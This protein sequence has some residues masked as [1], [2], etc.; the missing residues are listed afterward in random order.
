M[1]KVFY[2]KL[3]AGNQI[4]IAKK[5]I[6]NDLLWLGYN[7]A[8]DE[9]I[10]EAI[11]NE[12]QDSSKEWKEIWEPIRHSF[13]QAN[14][15]TQTSYA[16]AI[17]QFYTASEDDY[18]FT[19]LNSTMYYCHPIGDIIPITESNTHGGFDP[20]SRIRAT[21]GWKKTP[22]ED[23]SITLSERIISGRITKTKIFRGT[24]CELKGKDKEVFFNTLKWQFPEYEELENLRA[25]SIDLILKVIQELNAHDFE[26]LVDMVLTKSGWLRVG[27]LGGTVKAIDMEYLIPVENKQVYVQVK[28]VLTDKECIEALKLLSEELAFESNAI[29]YLTFH[30]NKTRKP[31]P[32]SNNQLIIKTL[33]GK[34]LAELC[35]NHQEVIDWLF[36]RTTGKN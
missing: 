9:T 21:T 28:S 24:I 30:T 17:R 13:P 36:Q 27:E 23:D 14:K 20:G 31:I 26:I 8:K 15:Q 12:Q 19:F 16:K 33:N 35:S 11:L 10:K 5:C 25:K 7:E 4:N 34:T 3:G 29:C 22:I 6:E 32:E 1:N 18:F 2:I